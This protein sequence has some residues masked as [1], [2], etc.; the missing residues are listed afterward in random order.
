MGIDHR[1]LADYLGAMILDFGI[2][3]RAFRIAP[4]DDE[5]FRYLTDIVAAIGEEANRRRGFLLRAH[6]GNF[7]LWIAGMF[8]DYITTREQRKGAPGL[9]YY[10]AMGARGFRL[11]SDHHLARQLDL[12]ELYDQVASAFP[13][14]RTALNQLS[15][16]HLFPRHR[17]TDRL[18]RQVADE[19]RWRQ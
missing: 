16:R 4:H 1:G 10:D 9:G 13:R 17:S 7:S 8:P 2:R 15:D 18:L 19:F 11:A 12:A 3:G 5:E 14:L 6:L